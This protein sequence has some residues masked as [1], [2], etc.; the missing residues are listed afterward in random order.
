M[1]NELNIMKDRFFS[2]IAHDLKSPFQSIIGFSELLKDRF[3]RLEDNKKRMYVDSIF[4]SSRKA[5]D[6]L[7]NLLCWARLQM[8]RM[9]F[10]QTLFDLVGLID[11]NKTLFADAYSKKNI[12]IDAKHGSQELVFADINMV[13]SVIR[14]LFS[15]AIKFTG[16][17]GSINIDISTAN[18]N[19]HIAFQDTGRGMSR[20]EIENLF[21]I[22]KIYSNPG[23]NNEEGTGLGL[24][25][26]HEFMIKNGGK[27][28]VESKPMQ[29][30]TF[31]LVL[32]TRE[33]SFQKT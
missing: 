12:S 17:G 10:E 26:C 5:Y 7:E 31:H 4:S 29:G 28:W 11:K 23:T 8:D 9:V 32:P 14:N 21:R 6:L 3:D 27:I 13:D 19:K 1:L 16:D 24:I 2:I 33:P 22:D 25:L 15:N 30:S 18:G 20:Q